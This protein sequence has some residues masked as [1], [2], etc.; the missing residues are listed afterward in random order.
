M[1][2]FWEGPA[3]RWIERLDGDPADLMSPGSTFETLN[4]AATLASQGRDDLAGDL[5]RA[6]AA[7]TSRRIDRDATARD[8][9]VADA[10]AHRLDRAAS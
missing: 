6:W 8:E 5:L 1:S 10:L 4:S 7:A 9:S 2:A 3:A